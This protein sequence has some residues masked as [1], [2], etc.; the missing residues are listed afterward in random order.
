MTGK[1]LKRARLRLKM[2]QAKL[3]GAIELHKNTVARMERGE[4]RIMKQ[5]ELA[6]RYLL[7]MKSKKGG[8][9]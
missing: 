5:T 7:V 2:S 8:E 1:E 9:K 6:V 3:G 4:L